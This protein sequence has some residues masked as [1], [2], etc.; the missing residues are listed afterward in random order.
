LFA[1][2][3][4]SAGAILF[5]LHFPQNMSRVIPGE[6][7]TFPPTCDPDL[8]DLI[9]KLL[10]TDPAHR[11]TATN[12]LNHP[13]SRSTFVDQMVLDGELIDQNKKIHLVKDLFKRIRK[14]NR[15]NFLKLTVSRESLVADVLRLF[16]GIPISKMK[17][18]LRVTFEGES[19]VD[20]GGMLVE[21][22]TLFFEKIL[23]GEGGYFQGPTPPDRLSTTTHPVSSQY[24]MPAPITTSSTSSSSPHKEERQLIHYEIFGRLL[25]KALYCNCRIGNRL[26]P[27]VFKF[28]ANPLPSLTI[29][30]LQFYDPVLANSFQWILA[31]NHVEEVG[32]NFDSI[33]PTSGSVPVTDDNKLRFVQRSIEHHLI[34]NQHRELVAIR[35]GFIQ[36]LEALSE[37]AAPFVTLLSHTDWRVLL[38]GDLCISPA[39]VV[40]LFQFTGFNRRSKVPIWLKEII[41]DL[42]EI[43]LRKFLV[44]V[45][46]SPSLPTAEDGA[47]TFQINVRGQYR[48]DALPIAHTCFF[49]LD[50]PDYKEKETLLTKLLYSIDNASTFEII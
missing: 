6:M 43:T 37:E 9:L 48:S 22:F 30:D 27:V 29:R 5:F 39:K 44:F 8:A 31:T 46:G 19:G 14:E 28:I 32:L 3:L 26:C 42:D 16:Q 13:Y 4:Y 20:E 24:A 40:Q 47:S 1:S 15:N 23:N 36:C 35:N 33:D 11:P 2:D 45:T 50:I 10:L 38:C 34:L 18:S 17:S 49:H 25:M 12:A 7:M 21:L 41:L